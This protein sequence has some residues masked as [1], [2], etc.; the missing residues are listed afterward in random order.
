[1]AKPP[2]SAIPRP[3]RI[4]SLYLGRREGDRLVY[5]G[6]ARTGYTMAA[7]REV[8]ERLDPLIVKRS[9]LSVP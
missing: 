5:A 2:C 1:M 8:R 9:P 6:K 7:A 3:R 4:A